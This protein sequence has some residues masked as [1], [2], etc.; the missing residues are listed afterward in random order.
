MDWKN[1]QVGIYIGR[2]NQGSLAARAGNCET[3]K[4]NL[5]GLRSLSWI[6]LVRHRGLRSLSWQ[7]WLQFYAPFFRIRDRGNHMAEA[8]LNGGNGGTTSR[9]VGFMVTRDE[10]LTDGTG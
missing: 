3:S 4:L 6:F 2:K 10:E 8:Y 1:T 5:R 9:Y 7:L